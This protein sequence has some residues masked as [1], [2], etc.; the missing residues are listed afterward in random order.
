MRSLAVCATVTLILLTQNAAAQLPDGF[1]YLRDIAPSIRQDMRYAG[2]FNFTGNRV[3]GYEAAQ[4]I[5]RRSAAEALARAQAK[6]LT[7]GYSLKVYDCYRPER[8]V[9]AFI[10]W[11][12]QPEDA[13]LSM[14]F[15][16]D[17]ASAE[18]FA[19]GYLATRSNH[20]RG[21]AVDITLVRASEPDIPPSFTGAGRCDGPFSQRMRESSLDM[22]TA[23]D[24]AADKAATRASGVNAEVKANRERLLTALEA[25]GFRNYRREWWHFD[26]Q[27]EH[28]PRTFDFPVR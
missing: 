11:A 14:L 20:S 4:C 3:V 1:V 23:Y 5:L 27:G 6:L 7:T 12:K 16:P 17:I 15:N 24:C 21:L 10:E 28:Q 9:R 2:P 13:K 19:R 8:A 22:G 25:V 26:F 18:L